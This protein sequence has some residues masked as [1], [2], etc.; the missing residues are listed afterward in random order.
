MDPSL[1]DFES[2]TASK[3]KEWVETY[4]ELKKYGQAIEAE[5]VTGRVLLSATVDSIREDL[6]MGRTHA[7]FLMSIVNRIKKGERCMLLICSVDA[8][9]CY[10]YYILQVCA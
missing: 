6:S 9:R 10:G 2:Y 8:M 3:V 1:S 5:D 7:D 4:H